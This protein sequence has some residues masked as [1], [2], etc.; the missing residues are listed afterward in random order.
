MIINIIIMGRIGRNLIF[1]SGVVNI[2]KEIRL[3][4]ETHGVNLI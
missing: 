1:L 2:L 3:N 4:M